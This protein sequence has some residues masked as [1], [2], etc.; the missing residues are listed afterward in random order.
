MYIRTCIH[1]LSHTYI[2]TYVHTYVHTDRYRSLFVMY[3]F[4][5]PLVT[6]IGLICCV[7][8]SSLV[9]YIGLICR[10]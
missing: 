8:R 1:V 9:M 2:Y 6:Y 5:A 3:I 10:A 7:L 4:Q